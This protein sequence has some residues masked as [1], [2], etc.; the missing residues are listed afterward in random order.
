MSRNEQQLLK[1]GN[2]LSKHGDIRFQILFVQP[3]NKKGGGTKA[4][5]AVG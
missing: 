2:F 5:P 1:E 4:T 3:F